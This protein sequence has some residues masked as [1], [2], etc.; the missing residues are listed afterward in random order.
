M[1]ND[2]RVR[3]G[4]GTSGR[5]SSRPVRHGKTPLGRAGL[6]QFDGNALTMSWCS[7]SGICAESCRRTS[8]TITG[9]G[10]T[11][12]SPRTRL[13][14]GA[15]SRR[16]RAGWCRCHASVGSITNTSGERR[17]PIGRISRRDSC[18]RRNPYDEE[19]HTQKRVWTRIATR[20]PGPDRYLTK[21][22][23]LEGE[24][25]LEGIANEFRLVP[26]AQLSHEVRPMRLHG[27]DAD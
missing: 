24:L 4:C 8:T 13:S 25:T 3:R 18:L 5:R 9:P 7:A 22:V 6:A 12:P 26:H 1:A 10:L 20:S 19:T 11:Y 23:L 21:A 17:E 16:A 27:S 2:F 15:C 14:R